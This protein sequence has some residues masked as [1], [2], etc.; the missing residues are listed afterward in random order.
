[1]K[2]N[3]KTY[4]YIIDN[5]SIEQLE[6]LVKEKKK[7]NEKIKLSIAKKYFIIQKLNS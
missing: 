6:K 1:M 5:F 3:N 7:E 2:I 4:E